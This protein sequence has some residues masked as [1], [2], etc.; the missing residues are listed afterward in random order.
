[1]FNVVMVVDQTRHN[2]F[3]VRARRELVAASVEERICFR[4]S[5]EALA[6]QPPKSELSPAV[7]VLCAQA[8]R[9]MDRLQAAIRKVR[10]AIVN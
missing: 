8:D 7:T 4:R 10:R 6:Q 3:Y 9:A 1:M 2:S 5:K